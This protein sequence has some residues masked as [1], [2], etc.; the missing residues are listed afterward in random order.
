MYQSF[1]PLK[2]SNNLN[3]LNFSEQQRNEMISNIMQKEENI[4]NMK[5]KIKRKLQKPFRINSELNPEDVP[6]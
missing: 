4:R 1:Q 2:K 6:S 5:N 3:N